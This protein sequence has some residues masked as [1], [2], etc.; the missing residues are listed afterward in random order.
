MAG[1]FGSRLVSRTAPSFDSSC[2]AQI[3][4]NIREAWS[5]TREGPVIKSIMYRKHLDV[6]ELREKAFTARQKAARARLLAAQAAG[7][8]AVFEEAAANLEAKAVELQRRM[9]QLE[10]ELDEL[11]SPPLRSHGAAP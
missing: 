11:V 2:R 8:P 9:E 1:E 5:P 10:A 4:W 6:V 3:G 7:Q